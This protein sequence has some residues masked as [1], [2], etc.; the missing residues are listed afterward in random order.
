MSVQGRQEA[1]MRLAEA[2][3]RFQEVKLMS[4]KGEKIVTKSLAEKN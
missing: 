2:C 3:E 4:R 1:K